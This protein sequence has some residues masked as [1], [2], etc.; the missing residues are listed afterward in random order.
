LI[1]NTWW[2][3]KTITHLNGAKFGIP[4]ADNED[5]NAM[6][7]GTIALVKRRYV[8]LENKDQAMS[9]PSDSLVQGIIQVPSFPALLLFFLPNSAYFSFREALSKYP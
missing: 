8:S 2:V 6:G 7:R 5:T 4:S 9:S 3:E 1:K